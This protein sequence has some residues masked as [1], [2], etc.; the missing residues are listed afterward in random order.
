MTNISDIVVLIRKRL[1]GTISD[2]E[3]LLL[4]KWIAENPLYAELLKKAE[5]KEILLED[6]RDW[7]LLRSG[8]DKGLWKKRLESKTL[9]KIHS[10][11]E[12]YQP[13]KIYSFRRLVSYAAILLVISTFAFLVYRNHMENEKIVEV[14]DLTPGSNKALI[15]LSDGS[16]IELREDQEGVVLGQ[17]MTYQDG[18]LITK[19]DDEKIVYSTIATPRG[20]QY[21]ITLSDGTKVWLNADTKLTYPSHFKDG[22]REVQLVG[23]A[24]FE[25]ATH[26]VK[27]NKVPFLV[28]TSKQE[29][30]VL[31]TQF[32][33]KAYADD[34]GDT[35]TTL[36]EGA[37]QLHASGKTL[38]LHPGEQGVNN[39][40][41]LNKKKVEVGQYIA[42]KNNEFVFDETE[43]QEALKMLS[44]WYDF[45]ISPE[46]HFPTTHLYG[47]ISR[48]KSLKE[49]LKI[50]ESSGLKFKI[51]RSGD[52]NKLL[53]LH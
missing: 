26:Y 46:N 23:E 49:V 4:E 18:T 44:R 27:G 12:P 16:V 2:Q 5:D 53:I 42:W 30:E 41:G 28:K 47:S 39:T 15:T 3:L 43:L 33:I 52:R 32:N 22:P 20:G 17:E 8:E 29:V 10:A 19:L 13:R 48:D 35:R 45:D 25:V 38:L 40:Q 24:Y 51:E 11:N 1:D 37:V 36:V 21:H 7:L 50:M 9:R 14:H 6:I 34:A 31:G